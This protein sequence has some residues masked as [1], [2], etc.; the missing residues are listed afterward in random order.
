[1]HGLTDLFSLAALVCLVFFPFFEVF[2]LFLTN[3]QLP[4]ELKTCKKVLNDDILPII[5]SKN[6]ENTGFIG[7]I[8]KIILLY[9]KQGA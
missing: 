4:Y 2:Y 5:H 9:S 1:M 8:Q 6:N 3:Y 7:I